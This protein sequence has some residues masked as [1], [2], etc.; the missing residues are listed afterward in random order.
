MWFADLGAALMTT[1]LLALYT[2]GELQIWHLYTAEALTSICEA[3]QSPAYSAAISMLV[4]KEQYT[5]VSGMRSMATSA[6]QVLAPSCAG[7]LLGWVTLRG[8]MLIDLA[9]FLIAMLTLLA[10]RIPRP[11]ETPEDRAR[12]RSPWRE[13]GFG[14][15]YIFQRPGLLGLLLI[16]LGINLIASL[17]WFALLDPMILARSGKS[18]LALASVKSALGLGG[19]AG[20]LVVSVWGGPRHRIHSILAGAAIS[21][22]LS[23]FLLAI[24][25]RAPVWALAAFLG[26]FFI[27]FIMSAN[28]SIWQTKVAPA[29][30]G[31]VFSVQGMLQTATI[32]VGSLL[33]GPLADHLFEPAMAA[34]G[35]LA[36]L[37][38]W[39]VGTGPGAGMALMFAGTAILGT[40]MS[41]SGYLFPAVRHVET[42]LPD[43]DPASAPPDPPT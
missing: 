21:F 36:P 11:V 27:P 24:G 40:G 32:P 34:E 20:G 26:S 16:F 14:F 43:H 35:S 10:V 8:I 39:L 15:Q 17:T 18:A 42:D 33:A 12:R 2:T 31:R 25:T 9:T 30:Q 19:L 5:R 41:L 13:V 4:P 6:S 3:F 23:D 1:A 22:L 38:G 29:A 7:V 28:H 37:F